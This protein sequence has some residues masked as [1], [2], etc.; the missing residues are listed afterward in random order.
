VN[1]K[2]LVVCA[3]RD[4]NIALQRMIDSV[5]K[6]SSKADIA[7]YIDD[8]QFDLYQ[9][10]SGAM[11]LIGP[12]IGPVASLNKLVTLYPNYEAYGAATDDCTFISNGWDEWVLKVSRN[13]PGEI[14][15][16]APKLKGSD[17]MDFPWATRRW[18]EVV[19]WFAFPSAYHF[20]WDIFVE[21]LGEATAI[22]YATDQEFLMLHDDAPTEEINLKTATDAR[23]VLPAIALERPKLIKRL[24]AAMEHAHV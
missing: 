21:L 8:D 18:I 11:P 23:N 3:S 15:V 2:V 16:I 20:Y 5:R 22:K 1:G 7:V 10:M 13:F 24:K 4:R 17:R 9:D 6:T 19:G 12:R 14:G